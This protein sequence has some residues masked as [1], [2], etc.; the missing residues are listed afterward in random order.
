MN[1]VV[2]RFGP[3]KGTELHGSKHVQIRMIKALHAASTID[4]LRP[5]YNL[6]KSA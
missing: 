4:F 3:R 6:R 5:Q 2:K 1:V